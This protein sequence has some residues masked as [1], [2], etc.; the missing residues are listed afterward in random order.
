MLWG[1][2]LNGSEGVRIFTVERVS[3]RFHWI[4]LQSLRTRFRRSRIA[5]GAVVL[6]L[7]GLLTLGVPAS[8]AQAAPTEEN[9]PATPAELEASHLPLCQ[10]Q[11]INN[12]R[13]PKDSI[14][15]RLTSHQGDPYDPA[16]VERGLQLV[17]EHRLFRER[18]D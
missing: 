2:L 18:P 16:A 10:P 3:E 17:V 6:S 9:T 11:V 8:Y 12:R 5:S 13:I 1:G 14:L 4:Q 7:V 15:A